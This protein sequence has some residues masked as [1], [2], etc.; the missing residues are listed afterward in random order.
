VEP[1]TPSSANNHIPRTVVG[2]SIGDG[3]LS[4]LLCTLKGPD[5][6]SRYSVPWGVPD[7]SCT[8]GGGVVEGFE[9]KLHGGCTSI[10][11]NMK[12][13][14][15]DT[16]SS[17][18]SSSNTTPASSSNHHRLWVRRSIGQDGVVEVVEEAPQDHP[19]EE[20]DVHV[21]VLVVSRKGEKRLP[22]AELPTLTNE[23]VPMAY[24]L[25]AVVRLV[26]T[27]GSPICTPGIPSGCMRS[28]PV[29]VLF[30]LS[31]SFVLVKVLV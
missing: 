3:I 11:P 30:S 25:C 4:S 18:S 13:R 1:S 26:C 7:S 31:S 16:G 20:S 24:Q 21:V 28:T 23:S 9:R 14:S 10:S 8:S 6:S 12:G 2:T 22:T 5:L 17:S 19:R 27:R 15:S 29:T